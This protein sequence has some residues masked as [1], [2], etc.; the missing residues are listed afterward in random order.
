[1]VP[2]VERERDRVDGGHRRV[3]VRG[4]ATPSG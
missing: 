4:P 2:T 3:R 1:M